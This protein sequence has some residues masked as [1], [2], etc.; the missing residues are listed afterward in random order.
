MFTDTPVRDEIAA[1]HTIRQQKKRKTDTNPARV[2][3]TLFSQ[4]KTQSGQPKKQSPSIFSESDVGLDMELTDVS[5]SAS[6]EDS[7][8]DIMEGDYIIV[9]IHATA[10][11]CNYVARVDVIDGDDIEGIFLRRVGSGLARG[12]RPADQLTLKMRHHFP[13]MTS[14]KSCRLQP[15]LGPHLVAQTN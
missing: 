11:V 1:A 12:Q 6:D 9:K 14:S 5:D 8:Q 13:V 4:K 2:K 10:R 3:K 15:L 7:L